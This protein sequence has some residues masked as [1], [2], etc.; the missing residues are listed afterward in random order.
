[1][2]TDFLTLGS[3]TRCKQSD[4]DRMLIQTQHV[5]G[6]LLPSTCCKETDKTG[7]LNWL[8]RECLRHCG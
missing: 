7:K 2:A 1:L 3:V 8:I 4:K 6:L 5:C